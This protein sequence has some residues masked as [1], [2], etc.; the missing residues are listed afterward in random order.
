[1]FERIAVVAAMERE[2]SFL[3]RAMNPADRRL[4]RLVCG[5]IGSKSVILLRSGV[6]PAKAWE[7]LAELREMRPECIFS[8]G[9]SGGLV[10]NLHIGDLVISNQMV[11]DSDRSRR[12]YSAPEFVQAA[13]DCC[14]NLNVPFH[15][16]KTVT[17]AKVAATPDEKGRLAELHGAISV[18][19]ES[20]RVAAWA[21][22][23]GIPMLAL[24]A[25]SDELAHGIP[26][27]LSLIFDHRGKLF[28]GKLLRIFLRRP[29]LVAEMM[30]LRSRFGMSLRNL[31]HVVMPLV[32]DI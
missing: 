6:G 7:R 11:D 22:E 1:M 25:V 14:G 27:E 4:N 24:R 3:R 19:M 28:V 2:C 29:G 26:Q 15:V 10:Q 16:G 12:L 9:C 23:E 32:A 13:V 17:T 30:R 18:D 31:E 8:I 21:A 5:H 20:A